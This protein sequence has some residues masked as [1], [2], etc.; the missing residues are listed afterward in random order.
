MKGNKSHLV[1]LIS[2]VLIQLLIASSGMAIV[3]GVEGSVTGTVVT[4]AAGTVIRA[5]DGDYLVSGLDLTQMIGKTVKATGLI[6]TGERGKS[7]HVMSF[8]EL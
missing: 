7:I 6:S 1:W 8:E 3:A 4:T 5:Q 2:A